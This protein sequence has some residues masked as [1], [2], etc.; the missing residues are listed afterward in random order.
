MPAPQWQLEAVGRVLRRELALLH[1][2][3]VPSWQCTGL[4][5]VYSTW[6]QVN[7]ARKEA[8]LVPQTLK[9]GWLQGGEESMALCSFQP[10][11]RMINF[12]EAKNDPNGWG[13][14]S[15]AT[16]PGQRWGDTSADSHGSRGNHGTWGSVRCRHTRCDRVQVT[17]QAW[18]IRQPGW[19]R[20]LCRP[21]WERDPGPRDPGEYCDACS[22]VHRWSTTGSGV[23][24]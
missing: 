14:R 7:Q 22:G 19:P 10:V 18:I 4:Q 24:Y 12:A 11:R 3:F 8:G 23:R 15:T 13:T 21:C 17:D 5:E 1:G 20:N 6:G 9:P 2:Q 16:V